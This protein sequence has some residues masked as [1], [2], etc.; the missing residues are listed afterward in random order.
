[1]NTVPEMPTSSLAVAVSP[2][3]LHDAMSPAPTRTGS[4]ATDAEAA[5]VEDACVASGTSVARVAST[6][7][8][9]A[10]PDVDRVDS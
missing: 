4:D 7:G 10:D 1:V 3:E 5:D 6:W 8:C 9:G 2:L